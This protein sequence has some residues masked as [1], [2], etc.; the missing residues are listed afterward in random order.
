V[1]EDAEVGGIDLA[2]HVEAGYEFTPAAGPSGSHAALSAG[3]RERSVQ[4]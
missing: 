4:A 3:A 1:S 2:V